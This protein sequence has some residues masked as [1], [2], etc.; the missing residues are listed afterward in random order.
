MSKVYEFAAVC[1]NCGVIVTMVESGG[2]FWCDGKGWARCNQ[3]GKG[4]KHE[5]LTKKA[6]DLIMHRER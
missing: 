6:A 1:R 4:L 5:P 2:K 3:G